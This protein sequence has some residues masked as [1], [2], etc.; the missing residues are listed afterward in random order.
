MKAGISTPRTQLSRAEWIDAATSALA[1]K[2]AE[3]MCV[4]ILAKGFGVTK[5]SFYWHFRDRHDL[6]DAVLQSWKESRIRDADKQGLAT[7]G[8]ERDQLRQIIGIYSA[9]RNSKGIAIELAVRDWAR[10]DTQAA[11]V[12]K[13]VDSYRLE[14]ACKLFAD[15]GLSAEEARSRSLLLYFYVLGQSLMAC[16]SKDPKM[17]VFNRWITERIVAD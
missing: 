15:S 8:K 10:H 9:N 16:N 6:A 7:P 3:G 12:V 5:G 11:A 14:H 17:A 13:E 1:D 2:G 4:E